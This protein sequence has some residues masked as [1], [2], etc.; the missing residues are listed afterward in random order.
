MGK[1]LIKMNQRNFCKS[2]FNNHSIDI[3]TLWAYL[4][5]AIATTLA[6]IIVVETFYEEAK[7]K[8]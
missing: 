1:L 2:L 8:N 3:L 4:H 6:I 5:L 7:N